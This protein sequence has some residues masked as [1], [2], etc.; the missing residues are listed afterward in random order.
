MCHAGEP[1]TNTAVCS[2]QGKQGTER[3]VL[4][5]GCTFSSSSYLNK[6]FTDSC[7]PQHFLQSALPSLPKFKSTWCICYCDW[8]GASEKVFYPSSG[9]LGFLPRVPVVPDQLLTLE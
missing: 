9:L 7:N 8:F 2:S 6:V 5:E 1:K 4:S 3:R